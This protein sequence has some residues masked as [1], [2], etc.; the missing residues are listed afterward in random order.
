MH[1][2]D[3]EIWSRLSASENLFHSSACSASQLSSLAGWLAARMHARMHTCPV[4]PIMTPAC[5]AACVAACST[6][7]MS[8]LS[9][10]PASVKN[11]SPLLRPASSSR[12]ERHTSM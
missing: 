2:F 6:S 12:R 8:G 7:A 9:S 4:A 5:A 3:T 11:L 10:P 1:M